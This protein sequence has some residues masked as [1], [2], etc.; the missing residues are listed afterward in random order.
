MSAQNLPNTLWK[1]IYA[2][3]EE[4]MKDQPN[5]R[6]ELIID[7]DPNTFWHSRYS[8]DKELNPHEILIDLGARA[9][10]STVTLLPR[11]RNSSGKCTS[12][13]I[14]ISDNCRDWKLVSKG[15]LHW[16]GNSDFS[17]KNIDFK[18]TGRYI[19]FKH[20]KTYNNNIS[21]I[22][23]ASLAEFKLKGVYME[24]VVAADFTIGSLPAEVTIGNK[25]HCSSTSKAFLS[26]ITRYQWRCSG[27]KV[28][29][30]TG[31][32]C[33]IVFEKP[34]T[35]Q[36]V[37][38][39]NNDK[40]F[41][42]VK[43]YRKLISVLP[44]S[45]LDNRFIKVD[46]CSDENREYQHSVGNTLSN[47]ED[48]WWETSWDQLVPLPHFIVYDLGAPAAISGIGYLPLQ[49]TNEGLITSF[50]VFATNDKKEW[51]EPIV[52]Q[53]LMHPDRRQQFV[54]F[55]TVKARYIKF[56]VDK[57]IDP[58]SNFVAFSKFY[59][60][61]EYV[62]PLIGYVEYAFIALMVVVM[63]LFFIRR[64]RKSVRTLESKPEM[65]VQEPAKE[66]LHLNAETC[67]YLFGNFRI[68]HK[69]EEIT[70]L[71]SPKLKQLFVLISYYPEGIS[72]HRMG[73]LLWSGMPADKLINT[74]G[75]NIQRLKTVLK[76]I[77]G[78]KL[79]YQQK[80]WSMQMDDSVY[81]D[82]NRYKELKQNIENQFSLPAVR[83]LC[84]LVKY[85]FL[86]DIDKEWLDPIKEEIYN[87]IVDLFERLLKKEQILEDKTVLLEVVEVFMNVD[88]L[89]EEALRLKIQT[90]I[91]LNKQSLAKLAFD[92]FTKKY[93]LIYDEDFGSDYTGFIKG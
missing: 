72:I 24:P 58:G 53:S 42:S 9:K 57:T 19:K 12:Y 63:M 93:R 5:C 11:Q 88:E 14:S 50:R 66:M 85:P 38:Q 69:G 43:R 37:L 36:I 16:T 10:I 80:S 31:K 81:Y 17:E 15:E 90:L 76:E 21:D 54:S 39:V 84:S 1:V 34:G 41:E 79:V 7:N 22:D 48:A 13:E 2:S 92:N 28:I 23:V 70:S 77:P 56:Q 27:A 30:G 3:S 4:S 35:Y 40:G 29:N 65:I 67:I 25:L 86:S 75:T 91:A 68:I 59:V 74:R 52:V 8:R 73:E 6:K 20:L 82:L 32:D 45:L 83:E 78:I 71:L 89:N 61:G 64:K 55:K 47:Q 18:A 62:N 46:T 26:K 60:Y 49:F 33:D 87:E 44:A 51:G